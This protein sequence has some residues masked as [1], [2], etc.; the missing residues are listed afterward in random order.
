MYLKNL[1]KLIFTKLFDEM[2]SGRNRTRH[3]E[4]RNYGDTETELKTK[5]QNSV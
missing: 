1:F 3:L 5:I 2:Q 4:F